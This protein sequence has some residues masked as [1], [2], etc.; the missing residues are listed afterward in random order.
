MKKSLSEYSIIRFP[1]L[2]C[3][4]NPENKYDVFA[5]G[6]SLND[7]LKHEFISQK[8]YDEIRAKKPKFTHCVIF[9]EDQQ[10]IFPVESWAK[11]RLLVKNIKSVLERGHI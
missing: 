4:C 7:M 11:G 10:H 2:R 8:A 5:V 3:F 1:G 9:S 6:G